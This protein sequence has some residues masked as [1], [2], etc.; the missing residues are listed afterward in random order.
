MPRL[1]TIEVIQKTATRTRQSW[2]RSG[3]GRGHPRRVSCAVGAD[4]RRTAK[5]PE[6]TG[7]RTGRP[8]HRWLR[9]S[10][11]SPALRPGPSLA[12]LAALEPGSW[13]RP[14]DRSSVRPG[15]SHLPLRARRNVSAAPLWP[16]RPYPRSCGTGP[17]SYPRVGHHCGR[18]VEQVSP[19]GRPASPRGHS[20]WPARY[21]RR[22][23]GARTSGRGASRRSCRRCRARDR[24]R[25]C[26]APRRR[27]PATSRSRGVR[28][29]C[30]VSV[31]GRAN[32]VPTGR[33]GP[34]RRGQ[35]R[36]RGRL[37][38]EPGRAQ[39]SRGV[40]V[41]RVVVGRQDD[42][43]GPVPAIDQEVQA[44][45][46][47]EPD[48]EQDDIGDRAI[49]QAGGPSAGSSDPAMATTSRSGSRR[50]SAAVPFGHDRVVVDD[51]DPDRRHPARHSS[52]TWVPPP[53]QR[54]TSSSAP[55][56][57][58]RCCML[59]RPKWPPAV[60]PSRASGVDARPGVVDR[61]R[62]PG[63]CRPVADD[64][65]WPAVLDGVGE[66]LLGDAEDGQLDLR[67]RA[68][69]V[70]RSRRTSPPASRS[71]R[72]TSQSRAG[73]TPRSS[74]IGRRR[75]PQISRSRSAMA[76]AW[77]AP[78]ASPAASSR[79]TSRVRSWSASS[80][81]SAASAPARP[82]SPRRR[83]RAGAGR[84]SRPAAAAAP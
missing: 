71:M 47:A 56:A 29:T 4:A 55:I 61:Q 16:Q 60:A 44:A 74:R 65:R 75:S 45:V 82:P 14:E 27:A 48:V 30:G 72:S 20:A 12:G 68:R 13:D 10:P 33:H 49:V 51:R 79:R 70:G 52:A 77:A 78:S 3:G 40:D 21:G 84:G 6:G 35:L 26:S 2:V 34:D 63:R 32:D 8:A 7:G 24:S 15:G 43:G 17:R 23:R 5:A 67:G 50:S 42:D 69:A 25:R 41:L 59:S 57:S 36:D 22:R 28:R 83:G 19:A 38:D 81:R 31:A 1:S 76:R 64:D 39:P 9:T 46:V 58:A 18:T 37:E 53:G 54:R 11:E 62:H 73:P 66:R 80:W